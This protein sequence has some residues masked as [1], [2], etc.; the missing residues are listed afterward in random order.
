M[1]IDLCIIGDSTIKE[2]YQ[3]ILDTKTKALEQMKVMAFDASGT[4][5]LQKRIALV[6]QPVHRCFWEKSDVN[7]F[8]EKRNGP[9]TG[10]E[11]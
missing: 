3:I 6:V 7:L 9:Y 11:A 5:S 8:C 10:F 1:Y 2:R 4:M